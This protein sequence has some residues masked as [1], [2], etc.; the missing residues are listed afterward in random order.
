MYRYIDPDVDALL[1]EAVRVIYHAK[2]GRVPVTESWNIE[3]K[4]MDE[5]DIEGGDVGVAKAFTPDG[6]LLVPMTPNYRY[7][8]VEDLTSE[9]VDDALVDY[10]ECYSMEGPYAMGPFIIE[11]TPEARV[12]VERRLEGR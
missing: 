3:F 12:A 4:E 2:H 10:L 1:S 8:H 9:D 7:V 6:K 5:L 11:D